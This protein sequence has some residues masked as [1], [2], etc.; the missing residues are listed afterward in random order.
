MP[1]TSR[2]SRLLFFTTLG[3]ALVSA[4]LAPRPA[5][6]QAAA[7]VVS[8]APVSGQAAPRGVA[9]P[10]AA[11][12]AVLLRGP[13]DLR[14]RR[15]DKVGLWVDALE[16]DPAQ[17]ETRVVVHQGRPTLE[18]SFE[19][20]RGKWL[21]RAPQIT[22]DWASLAAL[23]VEGSGDVLADG[24]DSPALKVRLQGSGDVTLRQVEVRELSLALAGSGDVRVSGRSASLA[25]QLAGS[26]DVDASD[27][28]A[29]AVTVSIA[30]SGDVAVNASQTLSASIAGSGDLRYTG[31]PRVSTRV[32]GSGSVTRR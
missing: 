1:L 27:L 10:V 24:L 14:L 20:P 9:R 2:Q 5:W 19:P 29:E 26:G 30:G 21:R 4:L 18:I 13:A 3:L 12:E 22:V 7:P 31:D 23:T 16:A 28:V 17:I 32:A 11:F 15:G 6:A 8:T 25:V